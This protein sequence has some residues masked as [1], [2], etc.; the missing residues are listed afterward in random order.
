MEQVQTSN[1]KRTVCIVFSFIVV[2]II[3]FD[4]ISSKVPTLANSADIV[5][6]GIFLL[7]FVIICC[8]VGIGFSAKLQK[9]IGSKLSL[10][11]FI[12][13]LLCIITE[14]I[15]LVI[16][17]VYAQKYDEDTSSFSGWLLKLYFAIGVMQYIVLVS[18]ALLLTGTILM[19]CKN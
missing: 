6:L 8:A 12:L 18:G 2:V 4:L 13:V 14:I 16:L 9:S 17:I 1:K 15:M 10:F 3:L 5:V 19:L 11:G 7:F